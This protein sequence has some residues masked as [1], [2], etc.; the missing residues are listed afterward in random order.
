MAK[1]NWWAR[2]VTRVNS[3]LKRETMIVHTRKTRGE[4]ERERDGLVCFDLGGKMGMENI[5][6]VLHSPLPS[7]V[8]SVSHCDPFSWFVSC[9]NFMW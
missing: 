2:K 8:T 3:K 6:F 1:E 9:F 5:C 4:R 7:P